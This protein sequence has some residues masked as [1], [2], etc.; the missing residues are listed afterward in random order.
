MVAHLLWLVLKHI[1][2]V[3]YSTNQ[4]LNIID[5]HPIRL[6]ISLSIRWPLVALTINLLQHVIALELSSE[7]ISNHH[8]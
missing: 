3:L 8:L 2:K 1:L 6:P 5:C 7:V 4:R